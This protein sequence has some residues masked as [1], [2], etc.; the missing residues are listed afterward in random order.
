MLQEAIEL[1][2]HQDRYCDKCRKKQRMTRCEVCKGRGQTWTT[3]CRNAC[4]MKGW[5]CPV[6]GKLY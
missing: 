4:N 2:I 3:Q 1:A 6:H 5:L